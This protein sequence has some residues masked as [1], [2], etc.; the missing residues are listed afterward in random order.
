M[1]PCKL[2][3]TVTHTFIIEMPTTWLYDNTTLLVFQV[4]KFRLILGFPF[5]KVASRSVI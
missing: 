5:S 2:Y 1:M 4:F 3:E